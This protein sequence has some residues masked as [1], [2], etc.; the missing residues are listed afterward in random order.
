MGKGNT[1]REITEKRHKG[2][3]RDTKYTEKGQ[4]WKEGKHKEEIT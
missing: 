3:K 1:E 2:K 4:I